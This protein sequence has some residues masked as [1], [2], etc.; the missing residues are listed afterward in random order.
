MDLGFIGVGR[1]GNPMARHLAE[2]GHRVAV[3]D[4]QPEAVS[5][6]A[7]LEVVRPARDRW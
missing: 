6:L 7:S 5:R 1:M 4:T 2:A 3:Y